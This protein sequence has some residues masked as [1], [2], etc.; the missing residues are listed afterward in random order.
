MVQAF[1]VL[2]LNEERPMRVR[3]LLLLS[4]V[5]A[6]AAACSPATDD[7][8]TSDSAAGVAAATASPATDA[9]AARE[10]IDAANARFVDAA[11]RGDSAIVDA[12]FADDVVVMMPNEPAK[13]GRDAARKGFASTF[14]PG[15]VKDFSLKTDDVAVGGDLAVETGAYEMT[16]Q[17]RGAKEIKDNG[18]YITVWKRQ[19]DGS[20]KIIRDM[21]SSDLPAPR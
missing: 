10:A 16:L 4:A 14:Q 2:T 6:L 15:I 13:R 19:A 17:P 3:T 12:L 1:H 11:K 8:A 18:K 7:A 21:V 5:P 20:W 9:R